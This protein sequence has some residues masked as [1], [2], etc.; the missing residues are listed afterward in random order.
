MMLENVTKYNKYTKGKVKYLLP[1]FNT[2]LA[3]THL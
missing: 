3:Y 2:V 1:P